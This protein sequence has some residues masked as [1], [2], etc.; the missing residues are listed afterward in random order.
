MH[1]GCK[2][3]TCKQLACSQKLPVMSKEDLVGSFDEITTDRRLRSASVERHAAR[4]SDEDPPL[5]G[6]YRVLATGGTTGM[7]A[8]LPFDRSSWL[9]SSPSLCESRRPTASDRASHR[10]D[11]SPP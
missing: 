11:G 2:G 5:F 4:M 6:E 9:S 1:T 10:A 3:T 7:T 8:Y